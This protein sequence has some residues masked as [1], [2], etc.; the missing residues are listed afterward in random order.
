MSQSIRQF[1]TGAT[2]DA[3][4][5]KIDYEGFLSPLTLRRYGEYMSRHRK[6]V[7]GSLRDSDNWQRGIPLDAYMKSGFRHFMDWWSAHRGHSTSTGESVEE[8]LCA[9][10]F[11]ASGYLH[12]LLKARRDMP[13]QYVP[14][15][16][17]RRVATPEELL[18]IRPLTNPDPSYWQAGL[19]DKNYSAIASHP[20]HAESLR[21]EFQRDDQGTGV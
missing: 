15:K 21:D 13:A 19:P 5:D 7:D 2:R 11:N 12:E 4:T 6:Q 3:D 16:E 10:I 1:S 8:E 20:M 9:L 14:I 17:H 18:T